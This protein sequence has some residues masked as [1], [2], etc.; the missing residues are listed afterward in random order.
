MLQMFNGRMD[1]VGGSLETKTCYSK[2]LPRFLT[3]L[4][5]RESKLSFLHSECELS[6]KH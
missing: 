6:V 1:N 5:R 2:T 3:Y 4:P